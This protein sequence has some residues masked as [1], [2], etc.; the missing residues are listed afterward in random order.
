MAKG[1]R[2]PVAKSTHFRADRKLP[3]VFLDLSGNMIVPSTEGKWYTLIVQDDSTR[4][5]RVY[6]L[7]KTSGAAS[8]FG[9]F[10]AE[11][12]A[13]GTPS[14][15]MAVRSDNGGGCFAG[16]FGKLCR[17]RGIK[18]EF[19][20]ADSSMYNGVA[21]LAL[22]MNNDTALTARIQAPVLFPSAPTSPSLRAEAVSWARHVLNRS[23]RTG[24]AIV[25]LTYHRRALGP[26]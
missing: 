16:D 18:Q 4:F 11:V 25:I 9:S 23:K 15:A 21:E 10:L 13:D 1:L 14:P 20:P 2:N 6:F 5:T 24:I 8:A 22:A 7:G 12:R 19:T 17:K 3:R 26:H